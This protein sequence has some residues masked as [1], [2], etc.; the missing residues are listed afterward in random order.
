MPIEF[1]IILG[2]AMMLALGSVMWV[3]IMARR[4]R[5]F[6]RYFKRVLDNVYERRMELIRQGQDPQTAPWPDVMDCYDN[7]ERSSLWNWNWDSMMVY[8]DH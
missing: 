2:V 3:A 5:S 4:L 7:F 1:K 6:R 8:K